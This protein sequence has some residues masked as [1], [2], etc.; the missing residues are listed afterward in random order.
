MTT[1]TVT[2]S[3]ANDY[4]GN[5][6]SL[7]ATGFDANAWIEFT[8]QPVIGGSL[9]TPFTWFVQADSSGDAAASYYLN[10]AYAGDTLQI[11]ATEV[12]I[13]T[14]TGAVTPVAS[15]PVA[16]DTLVEQAAVAPIATPTVTTNQPDYAP[17]STA[18]FTANGFGANDPINFATYIINPTTGAVLSEGPVLTA[19]ADATGAV[20]TQFSVT[21]AYAN[22]TVELTATDPN[23]GQSAATTFTDAGPAAS[24]AQWA[25]LATN[26]AKA[27]VSG[28]L[29]PNSGAN[30]AS[31]FEGNDVPFQIVFSKLSVGTTYSIDLQ[32]QT[33]KGGV[34]AYDY[35]TSYNFSVPGSPALQ[36]NPTLGVTF[37]GS[38]TPSTVAIPLDPHVTDFI[39]QAPGVFTFYGA[40]AGPALAGNQGGTTLGFYDLTGSGSWST[41]TGYVGDT[42]ED[43]VVTFT[44][45]D[46]SGN[47]V[48]AFGGH[49]AQGLEVGLID[50]GTAGV[51]SQ[52]GAANISGSPYH[53]FMGNGTN[54]GTTIGISTGN[55]ELSLKSAVVVVPKINIEKLVSQ[56][57]G[58]N[59]YILDDNDHATSSGT[60]EDD[61]AFLE[62][63]T[64]NGSQ[65]FN[66]GN[67]H[68][69]V[70]NTTVGHTLSYE[71]VVTNT[72][73][74]GSGITE[75]GITVTDNPSS[76]GFTVGDLDCWPKRSVEPRHREC[77]FGRA[78]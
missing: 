6:T 62:G 13:D 20:T 66:S 55:E 56:D 32:W 45:E 60:A 29:N 37:N 41:A 21:S 10:P 74:P 67:L 5:T 77:G 23:T 64:I 39:S 63:L 58:A 18:T 7:S 31:Y 19:T 71:V 53:V 57:G 14:T 28:D 8:I 35:L 49:I 46:A 38:V 59:W 42:L 1:L 48:L 76:L 69:G 2:T 40:D 17:G 52:S 24:D 68:T 11:T 30:G 9:G 70:L 22:Q 3:D 61:V 50:W 12:Q 33:S 73:T 16:T 43:I 54:V 36:P 25:N 78:S 75:T 47:A 27:W 15:T 65:L 44:A 51:G 26:P 34:H 4:A 72:S